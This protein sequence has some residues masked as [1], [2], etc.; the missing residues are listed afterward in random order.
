M[1]W[2]EVLKAHAEAQEIEAESGIA[3]QLA[4]LLADHFASLLAGLIGD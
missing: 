4:S 3:P 2:D 1:P